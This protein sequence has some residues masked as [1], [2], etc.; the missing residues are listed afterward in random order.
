[1]NVD[2]PRDDARRNLSDDPTQPLPVTPAATV[3]ARPAA[4]S[5]PVYAPVFGSLGGYAV[6]RF[7]ALVVDVVVVTFVF[8]S[9]AFNLADRGVLAFAPRSAGGFGT[10][11]A[12]ALGGAI[13]FAMLFE[14][15]FE[16]TLGKAFFGLGV[17]RGTGQHA[18]LQRI[19]IRYLLLPIDLIVVGEVLA[20]VTR[21]HQRLGDLL[22][23]TV[24]ARH[25]IGG[26]ITALAIALF[27]GLVYAQVMFGGGLTS[28][29]AVT[30]EGT[31][32]APM[33]FGAPA[34]TGSAKVDDPVLPS[35][36]Q[37]APSNEA[38]SQPQ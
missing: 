2:P 22:A 37:N 14:A 30:V 11:V 34:P 24:V 38:S 12:I 16:T 3:V 17:R 8:A 32:F 28:A 19:V 26:F 33:L 25:R 13:V 10:I 23:G 36:M 31:Y 6:S 29:L 20:L 21:R 27:A 9:F 4:A 18:G 7:A 5:K 1:M 15:I 35:T